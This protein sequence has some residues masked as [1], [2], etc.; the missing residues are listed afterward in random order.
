[1]LNLLYEIK[2]RIANVLPLASSSLIVLTAV[3]MV[4]EGRKT[5]RCW[6]LIQSV[7]PQNLS[8]GE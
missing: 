7:N 4:V 5:D 1:M 3:S 8:I 2:H 6:L